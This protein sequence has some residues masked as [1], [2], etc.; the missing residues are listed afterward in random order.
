MAQEE[1][2]EVVLLQKGLSDGLPCGKQ[3]CGALLCRGT[4]EPEARHRGPSWGRA[5]GPALEPL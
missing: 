5:A 3:E 4:S 2:P 1:G